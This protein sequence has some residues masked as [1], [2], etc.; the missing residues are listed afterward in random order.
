MQKIHLLYEHNLVP[1]FQL[2][3]FRTAY[4]TFVYIDFYKTEI[5]YVGIG[6][7][8][9]LNHAPR[10]KLH[11]SFLRSLPK[12]NFVERK[13]LGEFSTE[14]AEHWEESL[15]TYYSPKFNISHGRTLNPWKRME[16]IGASF[17]DIYELH[18]WDFA[19]VLDSRDFAWSKMHLNEQ[20][21]QDPL[22][23][24]FFLYYNNHLHALDQRPI[25]RASEL[26]T[27]TQGEGKRRY[28][29]MR[30]NTPTGRDYINRRLNE[31][32]PSSHHTIGKCCLIIEEILSEL[33]APELKAQIDEETKQ[34]I[35]QP[36]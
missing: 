35:S 14:D 16:E 31:L 11:E 18:F 6:A 1:P 12:G 2:P 26:I 9:R 19:D 33:E 7:A 20:Y 15:I 23:R 28:Y 10:N 13:V 29:R 30:H 36:S 34:A 25:N 27:Q 21:Q 4:S 8:P 3:T 22:K 17:W 32:I 24:D 5:I